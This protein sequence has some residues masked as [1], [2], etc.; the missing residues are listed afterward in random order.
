MTAEEEE[1]MKTSTPLG[2][3]EKS[4]MMSVHLIADLVGF[5]R[6]AGAAIYEVKI[7]KTG[8]GIVVGDSKAVKP[9]E[10]VFKFDMRTDVVGY[11]ASCGALDSDLYFVGCEMG[12]IDCSPL[13]DESPPICCFSVTTKKLRSDVNPPSVPKGPFS[14]V[15][16]V[17]NKVYVLDN[18]PLFWDKE[19]SKLPFECLDTVTGSWIPLPPAPFHSPDF[20]NQTKPRF[21]MSGYAVLRNYI[22]VSLNNY[23]GHE[24]LFFSYNTSTRNWKTVDTT[25][26][27]GEVGYHGFKG[28]AAVI[29]DVIYVYL[30][31][32]YLIAYPSIQEVGS[33]GAVADDD[34]APD[35]SL[36]PPQML[37]VEGFKPSPVNP[38][39]TPSESMAE[40]GDRMLCLV[41]T[42]LSDRHDVQYANITLVQI[43]G[44]MCIKALSSS[45]CTLYIKDVRGVNIV[46]CF[47]L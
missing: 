26:I 44:R 32:S 6:P 10:L 24:I 34:D 39:D 13:R 17:N 18:A 14:L 29:D 36:G 33:C 30:Y 25:R 9:S 3:V 45:V 31:G 23:F 15:M 2:A 11:A 5:P 28:K 19:V 46:S 37:Q 27:V 8:G 21:V 4:P 16:G 41:Q 22:I 20:Y 40:V 38:T 47:G 35:L 43:D 42:G 1:A 12:R 7:S